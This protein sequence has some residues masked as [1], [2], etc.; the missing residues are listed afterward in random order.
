MTN[1]ANFLSKSKLWM[2]YGRPE[3]IF[4]YNLRKKRVLNYYLSI[5]RPFIY[6]KKKINRQNKLLKNLTI[7]LKSSAGRSSSDGH[8]TV[9]H[10]GGGHSNRYRLIDFFRSILDIPAI[11]LRVE[12]DPVRNAYIC[13]ICYANGT[14]S[15]LIQPEALNIGQVVMASTKWLPTEIGNAL[16]LS[17]I[18]IGTLVHNV[19]LTPSGKS[20][21]VRAA[22]TSAQI[23]KQSRFYTLL[24]L[25]S[26][27]LRFFNS[28]CIATVG[29]VSNSL[30]K[31]KH[32]NK[33]GNSRWLGRRPS[34]RGVA[35]NPIDHPHGG[36]Q[37][38]TSGGRPSVSAWAKLTKGYKTVRTKK[39]TL[40]FKSRL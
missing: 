23:L 33:A 27:E 13:L 39:N 30:F 29:V 8:I 24:K 28:N 19:Q 20:L 35:M 22:G 2:S 26:T 18:P 17:F 10:R 5:V 12:R 34:V 32:L 25:P 7:M 11:V 6:T 14:L 9:R 38:K 1:R 36:G 40:I 4:S 16:P 3:A 37:G 15:Y 31:F 21:I